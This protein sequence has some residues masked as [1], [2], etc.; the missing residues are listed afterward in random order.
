MYRRHFLTALAATLAVRPAWAAPQQYILDVEQSVVGFSYVLN[1]S[2]VNGRMPVKSA[3][4]ALDIDRLENSNV[5]AV[6][7]VRRAK[8]GPF[9]ATEAMKDASVLDT[10]MFP[11]I[12]FQSDEIERV[13]GGARIGG[14]IT[15]RDVTRP[16]L[17]EARLFRQV[18]TEAGDRSRLSILMTGDI[19]RRDFGATGFPRL[20]GPEIGLKILTR[21]TLESA[22]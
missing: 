18:G 7:D 12:R 5:T 8:A 6:L 20:V 11:E 17:L 13:K 9:Y 15:I 3:D 21:V 1:G 19:D 14:D 16:I 2:K 4:I 10:R 22:R